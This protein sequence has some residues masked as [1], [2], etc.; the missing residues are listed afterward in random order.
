MLIYRVAVGPTRIVPAHA[1]PRGG[2]SYLLWLHLAST[3]TLA[4]GRLGART[5]PAGCYVYAGSA[6]SGLRGRL[7]RHLRD[8]RVH[9]WHLDWLLDAAMVAE[10][11]FA[12]G[13]QR[14]ECAW[15][16]AL[17]TVPGAHTPVARFGASDCRCPSHLVHWL[18]MPEPLSLLAVLGSDSFAATPQLW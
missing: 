16:Q 9:H 12:L 13:C 3:R 17:L 6:L 5:F 8:E 11:W 2:G 10:I 1:L 4:P 15:A 7:A 14:L 18:S